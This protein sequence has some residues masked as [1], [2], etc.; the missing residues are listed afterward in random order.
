MAGAAGSRRRLCA[1]HGHAPALALSFPPVHLRRV[2]RLHRLECGLSLGRSKKRAAAPAHHARHKTNGQKQR[3]HR[4]SAS[5]PRMRS[6]P[7]RQ[8]CKVHGATVAPSLS[9][10]QTG[11]PKWRIATRR[12]LGAGVWGSKAPCPP[13]VHPVPHAM[14]SAS[15]HHPG[16]AIRP[17]AGPA[18]K[19]VSAYALRQAGSTGTHK[20]NERPRRASASP[21][22]RNA[23]PRRTSDAPPKRSVR[24]RDLVKVGK[25]SAA[26]CRPGRMPQPEHGCMAPPHKCRTPS[27]SGGRGWLIGST[28]GQSL[29]FC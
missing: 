26:R 28:E 22:T 17:G 12:R 20:A 23:H 11:G 18:R 15:A 13:V 16:E 21:P 2:Y 19:I 3:Q 9:E 5:H 10:R 25:R 4:H 27:V 29:L 8:S 6:G 1:D 7:P 24:P 14:L